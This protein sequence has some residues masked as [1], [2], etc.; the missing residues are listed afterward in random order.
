MILFENSKMVHGKR[1]KESSIREAL[2]ILLNSLFIRKC[3]QLISIIERFFLILNAT[4]AYSRLCSLNA[5]CL[6]HV[7]S[8]EKQ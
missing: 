2:K 8:S 1:T 3:S 6:L 5:Y 7:K 4:T